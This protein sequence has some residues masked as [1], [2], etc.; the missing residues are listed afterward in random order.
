MPFVWL[1]IAVTA[2]LFDLS[3]VVSAAVS[4]DIAP[5]E[6]TLMPMLPSA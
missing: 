3:A 5:V 2:E 1:K 6:S 4:T